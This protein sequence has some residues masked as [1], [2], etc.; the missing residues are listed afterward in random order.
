MNDKTK[1]ILNSSLELGFEEND[2]K[3]KGKYFRSRFIEPG[4]A[5]YNKFGDILITKETLNK[6]IDTMVGCPV[7]IDHK[8]VTDKNVN[9]LRVGVVSKVWFNEY[10][11]YFYCEGILTDPEA[12]DLV[13]NQGWNV[14]CAYSFVSDNTKRLHNGKEIDMEFTDGEFLHLALVQDPR[15]EGANIVV[16]SLVENAKD[17]DGNEGE[18]IT[19][20]GNHLFVKKGQSKEEA[21]KEFLESKGE[22]KQNNKE[23]DIALTM[24]AQDYEKRGN[25]G[26][27]DRANELKEKLKKDEELS[28]K[29]K[30]DIKT[31][32]ESYKPKD[33][34]NDN[35]EKNNSNIEKFNK[36]YK[37]IEDMIKR[38]NLEPRKEEEL[39]EQLED[40]KIKFDKNLE[41][42][43]EKAVLEDIND[44]KMHIYKNIKSKA[45]NNIGDITMSVLNDLKNFIMNT[46]KNEKE[47]EIKVKNEDKRKLI[48]EVGGILKGKVNDEIIRTIMKKMEEA[49][50]EPSEDGKANNEEDEK[51]AKNK[52]KNE[53]EEIEEKEEKVTENEDEEKD[54]KEEKAENK[55]VKNSMKDLVM[56]G[57][58]SVEEQKLFISRKERLEEGNK[59]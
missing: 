20:K 2:G 39:L 24:M 30:Q 31:A 4:V 53:E 28:D 37:T 17:W 25:K 40:Y 13:K 23:A 47:D 46:V 12:I 10:D 59:Y 22:G 44:F 18:W 7:I 36:E 34:S 43:Q 35:K 6:F 58:S 42:H 5:H 38:R 55:K 57:N 45:N 29:D 15:Y 8:D 49:S 32:I 16:N 19:V 41:P 3:G 33:K 54:E 26:T 27:V 11:G 52:C 9:K 14:S 50:Y 48:D 56:G 51:E 1:L 21:V